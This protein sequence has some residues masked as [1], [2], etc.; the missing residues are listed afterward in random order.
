MIAP[1]PPGFFFRCATHIGIDI[2]GT[3]HFSRGFHAVSLTLLCKSQE[4][5]EKKLLQRCVECDDDGEN[6]DFFVIFVCCFEVF[7]EF[8]V[9][10]G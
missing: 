4:R 6:E 2:D 8:L 10:F 3:H 9:T 7:E 1:T 5:C